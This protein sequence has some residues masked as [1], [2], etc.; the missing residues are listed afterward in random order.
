MGWSLGA[1][2]AANVFGTA[3][4]SRM[5]RFR[6]AALISSAFV[7]L[8][9]VTGGRG[10]SEGLTAIA[11]VDGIVPSALVALSAA[12]TVLVMTRL[13]LPVSTSQAIVGAL[14]GYTL[15]CSLPI[16]F[17][18]LTGIWATWI[19][20]PLLAGLMSAFLYFLI[21]RIFLASTIHLLTLDHYTRGALIAAGA[22]G[23]YALG[24]N[25]IA[26][27]TGLFIP[28]FTAENISLL[29]CIGDIPTQLFLIGSVA[30]ALGILTYSKRVMMSI[31]SNLFRLSPVAAF[32]VVLSTALV[33]FLFSSSAL[34]QFLLSHNLPAPPL[35]P[36][37]Q[38]QASVGA[39][40]GIAVAKRAWHSI[41]IHLLVKIAIGWVATPISSALLSYLLLII[42]I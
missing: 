19:Y 33:L 8:G 12:F 21:N 31:G 39:V 5:V 14:S 32:I 1:N 29:P 4:G 34:Q 36:V 22:I 17:S 15:A 26:N 9:A 7:M 35:I 37:S 27:V 38:S 25:N 24:A 20:G 10:A 13:S 42:V 30:I 2:D 23:S 3:V 28:T 18:S 41:N 11:A 6:S 40:L 16:N